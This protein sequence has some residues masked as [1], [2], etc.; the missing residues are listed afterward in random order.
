MANL[1]KQ[2]AAKTPPAVSKVTPKK[3]GGEWHER[4]LE[5][6]SMSLNVALAA[7][8][9]GVDRRQ[10]YRECDRNPQFAEQLRDAKAAAIE[11][12]EAA[13]YERAKNV[14]DTLLIFLLKSHK[15]EVYRE[16]YETTTTAINLNWD[17]LTD[18]ELE[19]I[20]AGEQPARVLADRRR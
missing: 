7:H 12:L 14:S 15:P 3:R 20:A 10:I 9:A 17:D 5:L 6:F 13:A 4:F 18:A 16:R 19:R 1:R 8:G 2:P 11:R